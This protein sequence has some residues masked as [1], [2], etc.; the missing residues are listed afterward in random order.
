MNRDMWKE[1]QTLKK[2]GLELSGSDSTNLFILCFYTILNFNEYY[3]YF[4]N[5]SPLKTK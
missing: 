4:F 5:K 3:S 1:I 2:I